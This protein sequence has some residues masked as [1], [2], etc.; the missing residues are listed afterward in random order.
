MT[1][2]TVKA[3]VFAAV[4]N[5]TILPLESSMVGASVA[6]MVGA[7]VGSSESMGG[8]IVQLGIS[9][10]MREAMSL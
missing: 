9:P 1:A 8:A 7:S 5:G 6:S 4:R 2:A 10:A 3:M